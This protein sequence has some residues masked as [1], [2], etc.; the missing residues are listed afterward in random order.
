MPESLIEGYPKLACHMGDCPD[1]SI[2]RRFGAL[3]SKNLL[4]LQAELVHLEE[5]LQALEEADSNSPVG[6]AS[7]YSRDWYWLE[8]S[9]DEDNSQQLETV[10]RIREKLK[11]YNDAVI[12]QAVLLGFSPP[13]AHDLQSLRDWIQ[14]PQMG[15]YPLIGADRHTWGSLDSPIDPQT[16]LITLAPPTHNDIFTHWFFET[17]IPLLHRLPYAWSRAK[18]PDVE[19]GII[20]YRDEKMQR[21]TAFLTTVVASLLPT[22]A[23]VVLYCVQE[24]RVRLGLIVG[25]T[26][27]FTACLVVFTAGRRGEVF[28]AS[29]AFAAVQVVFVSTQQWVG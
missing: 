10:L 19:S 28:A 6:N 23:I 2:F 3:N 27:V 4:Y 11:E 8:N 18:E 26:M 7:D 25:F 12:Q 24:M 16:D 29:S 5:K 13:R 21:Y 1:S 17:I 15:N 22:V 20:M 14:R 9:I